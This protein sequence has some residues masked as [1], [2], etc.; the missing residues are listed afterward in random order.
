M[1]GISKGHIDR[2]YNSYGGGTIPTTYKTVQDPHQN[3]SVQLQQYD[4]EN[5]DIKT[6]GILRNSRGIFL[7]TNNGSLLY[8]D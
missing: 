3:K 1:Q 5:I 2:D 8:K 6:L 4:L 7:I